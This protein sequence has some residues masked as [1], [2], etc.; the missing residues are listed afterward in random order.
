M[1]AAPRSG[2]LLFDPG[3][4]LPY[5]ARSRRVPQKGRNNVN[6][7]DVEHTACTDSASSFAVMTSLSRR[8]REA[9]CLAQI[10]GAIHD[11]KT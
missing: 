11:L 2:Q 4:A 9:D 6:K 3:I 1:N 10:S 7:R 8:L 5:P